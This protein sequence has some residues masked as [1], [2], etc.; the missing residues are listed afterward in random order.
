MIFKKGT[1]DTEE[2]PG[3]SAKGAEKSA[4]SAVDW[5]RPAPFGC[6]S[7]RKQETVG[8]LEGNREQLMAMV[9]ALT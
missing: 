1:R 3:F 8:L 9:L 7:E 2:R 4:P 5:P 6:D